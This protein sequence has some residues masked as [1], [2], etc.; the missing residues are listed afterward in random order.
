MHSPACRGWRSAARGQHCCAPFPLSQ[1]KI[2]SSDSYLYTYEAERNPD[3]S[4]TNKTPL[5]SMS[6]PPLSEHSKGEG[7]SMYKIKASAEEGC[8]FFL[9]QV[10]MALLLV[11]SSKDWQL[12]GREIKTNKKKKLIWKS[13]AS[14]LFILY[15]WEKNR[16]KEEQKLKRRNRY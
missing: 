16:E 2:L 1:G 8:N 12:C 5:I 13:E 7:V 3:A 4:Y 10:F 9:L 6:I 15:A 11:F 14:G